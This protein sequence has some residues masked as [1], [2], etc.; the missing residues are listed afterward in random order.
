S[1]NGKR[2]SKNSDKKGGGTGQPGG[3]Q[4]GPGSQ[5]ARSTYL[6]GGHNG[7]LLHKLTRG[8]DH[9]QQAPLTNSGKTSLRSGSRLTPEFKSN[10]FQVA[11]AL[12]P[13]ARRESLQGPVSAPLPPPLMIMNHLQEQLQA[14]ASTASL[15]LSAPSSLRQ[16]PLKVVTRQHNEQQQQRHQQRPSRVQSSSISS[17]Q[18]QQQ[19]AQKTHA[20][21]LP[22]QIIDTTTA[23]LNQATPVGTPPRTSL[24]QAFNQMNVMDA[25]Y[26]SV[27]Q[28]NGNKQNH[29]QQ[30]NPHNHQKASDGYGRQNSDKQPSILKGGGGATFY[31]TQQAAVPGGGG[32]G[33][34]SVKS[35]ISSISQRVLDNLK[36]G[37]LIANG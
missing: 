15:S 11:A 26:G 18:Q 4:K 21:Q 36:I 32:S 7:P 1:I 35:T 19:Q 31:E 28:L 10:P 30:Q 16:Q 6:F 20:W 3:G 34:G 22:F 25:H 2:P 9:H 14:S 33:G 13:Q 5:P 17:Q 37:K 12:L 29:Y 23:T 8:G 24:P 27:Q